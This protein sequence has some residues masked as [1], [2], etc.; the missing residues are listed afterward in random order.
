MEEM[1]LK[2]KNKKIRI[3]DTEILK[4][5]LGKLF[6][7]EKILMEFIFVNHRFWKK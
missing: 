7:F 5:I 4:I 6:V 2:G 3:V 1:D